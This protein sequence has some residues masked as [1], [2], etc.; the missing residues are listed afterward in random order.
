MEEHLRENSDVWIS[1][2]IYNSEG[3]LIGFH[4]LTPLEK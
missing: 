1:T 3:N 4:P 2:C